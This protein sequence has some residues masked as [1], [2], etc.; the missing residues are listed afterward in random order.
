MTIEY[1]IP[2]KKTNIHD[3]IKKFENKTFLLKNDKIEIEVKLEK[4]R[5]AFIKSKLDFYYIFSLSN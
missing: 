1:I 5:K 4:E 2:K 3:F